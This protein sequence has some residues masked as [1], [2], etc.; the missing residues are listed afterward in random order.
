[1]EQFEIIIEK[2]RDNSI[3]E[4]F[5]ID[6][7][8]C[9]RDI[10]NNIYKS[11]TFKFLLDD[12]LQLLSEELKFNYSLTTL[13]FDFV[14]ITNEGFNYLSDILKYNSSL[15][16]LT[17]S[18][19][20][21]N[22]LDYI[23]D[24]LKVN[25]YLTNLIINPYTNNVIEDKDLKNLSDALKINSSLTNLWL[26][27]EITDKGLEYISDALKINSSLINLDFGIKKNVIDKDLKYLSD[28]LKVNSSLINLSLYTKIN[29]DTVYKYINEA[30]ENNIT[31][32][33]IRV[34]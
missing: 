33:K 15:S 28:A 30:L 6:D 9:Y 13:R 22:G 26:A 18:S 32:T 21:F 10:F 17:I 31:L 14:N 7:R 24:A 19:Y 3:Y 16:N 23:S 27:F 34:T 12:F 20:S 4:L 25:S 8:F 2:I 29:K 1:M 11:P 5:C